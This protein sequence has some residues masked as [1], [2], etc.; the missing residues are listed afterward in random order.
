MRGDAAVRVAG[1]DQ[2]GD[3]ALAIGQGLDAES[4][5]AAPAALRATR[6]PRRRS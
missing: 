5:A 2:P 4:R 1:G 3:L 6:L